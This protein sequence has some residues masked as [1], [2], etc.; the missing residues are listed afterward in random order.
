VPGNLE[1]GGFMVPF[2]HL[3]SVF[4]YSEYEEGV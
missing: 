4:Q 2:I 1:S 3:R